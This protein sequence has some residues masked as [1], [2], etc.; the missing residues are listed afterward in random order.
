L[1]GGHWRVEGGG[2]G[3]VIASRRERLVGP[4][5]PAQAWDAGVM[6]LNDPSWTR[7][8]ECYVLA[9]VWVENPDAQWKWKSIPFTGAPT[10]EPDVFG[11]PCGRAF[12]VVKNKT[13]IV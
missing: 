2:S 8:K 12:I 3:R 4:R 13:F 1:R 7:T 11:R 6:A 9:S 10:P 5:N